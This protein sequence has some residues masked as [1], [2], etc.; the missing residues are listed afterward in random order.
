MKG[1]T[2]YTSD[3]A[4]IARLTQSVG[5]YYQRRGNDFTHTG[6]LI[7]I[8]PEGKVT[9]YLNGTR[10]LPFEFKMALLETSRGIPG[11]TINKVLQY[12]YSYDPEGQGYVLNITRIAGVIITF[13]LFVLFISL[14]LRSAVRRRKNTH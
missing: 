5:F 11:P 2:F 9:R 4:N 10:F 13:I 12:C 7:F 6:T 1:W 8:S 3:S 14:V